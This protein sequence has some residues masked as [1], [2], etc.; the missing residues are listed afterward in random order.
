V[1]EREQMLRRALLR[2]LG[3]SLPVIGELGELVHLDHLP[4]LAGPLHLPSDDRGRSRLL[5]CV[6]HRTFSSGPP[7]APIPAWNSR[8]MAGKAMPTTVVSSG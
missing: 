5:T 1:V 4:F 6:F 8:P 2:G 7:A 3:E